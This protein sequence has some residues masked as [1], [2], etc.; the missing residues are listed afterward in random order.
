[1]VLFILEPH[2]ALHFRRR[3][4]KGAQRVTRERVI[5]SAS[6][7]ILKRPTLVIL[8]LRIHPLEKEPFNLVRRIQRVTFFFK[9][10]VGK[11]FQDAADVRRISPALLLNNIAENQY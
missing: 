10:L 1:M 4:N 2:R 7:Y 3:V 5:V 11:L 9:L 6:I 8:S